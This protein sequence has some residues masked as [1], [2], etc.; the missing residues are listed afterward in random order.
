MSPI[1]DDF[2]GKNTEFD[3]KNSKKTRRFSGKNAFVSLHSS[4]CR[5]L[6]QR[7]SGSSKRPSRGGHLP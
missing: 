7:D 4:I 3:Y 5:F 1:N 6:V 2:L